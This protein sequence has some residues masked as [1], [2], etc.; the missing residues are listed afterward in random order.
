MVVMVAAGLAL[1]VAGI[2]V[3]LVA[4]R[5]TDTA[6]PANSPE[7][8]VATY[9]R[10]LQNGQADQAYD[11]V[12]IDRDRQAFIRQYGD[13]SQRTH[14]VTLVNSNTSGDRATVTVDLSTFSGGAFGASDT[15][16]RQTFTLE[17]RGGKWRITGPDYLY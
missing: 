14:R 2:I 3:A 11:L 8:T 12:A 4:S 15:T 7:G 1:L 16:N 6:Y 17:Q 10:L 9:L 5:R 13:W